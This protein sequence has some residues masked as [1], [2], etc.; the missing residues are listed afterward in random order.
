MAAL[1]LPRLPGHPA[2]PGPPGRAAGG[3]LAVDGPVQPG[4]G[5]GPRPGRRGA[6]RRART[7]SPS[8][9][10]RVSFGAVL[11]AVALVR[12]PPPTPDDETGGLWRRIATGA[13]G[14]WAEPGC[15]AAILA[16]AV[17]ALLLSPFIALIPAVAFKL[18]ERRGG[19]DVGADHGPGRGGGGGRPGPGAAGPPVRA[20]AGAAGRTC[21][22]LPALLVALRPGPVP[23]GGGGGP[24]RRWARRY[25]G[26]L[27]GLGTVVQL[28]APAALRAR[29][30][31]LYM[32]ALGTVYP[33]GAVIQGALG[34]RFG[35]RTVTAGGAVVFVAVVLV[36]SGRR[37]PT[38]SPP[39]TTPPDRLRAIGASA[40]ARGCSWRSL[41]RFDWPDRVS[42]GCGC[43]SRGGT[44]AGR[45]SRRTPAGR[46]RRPR[47][48]STRR[49]PSPGR[50]R[51]SAP[52]RADQEQAG[53][54]DQPV[55]GGHPVGRGLGERGYRLVP[56]VGGIGPG[57]GRGPHRWRPLGHR[58]RTCPGP[59]ARPADIRGR[60]P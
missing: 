57:W 30:L 40:P 7:R 51:G 28:R 54:A 17:T 47:P 32:V 42:G 12:L 31:S 25:I 18:F 56:L 36:A 50:R 26:I 20:P 60:W 44:R 48:G 14:A 23:A 5:G 37:A 6:G 59:G 43:L 55:G 11:V 58:S 2:R 4:P 39:S 19:G 15:R 21:V 34:D 46:R 1:G 49:G 38:W 33:V 52:S 53:D 22:V 35:L 29:I 41:A 10:T 8:P 13:R 9:S 45:R 16:I 27:S 3:Q 24:G